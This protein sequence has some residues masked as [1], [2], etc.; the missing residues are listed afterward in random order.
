MERLSRSL[1]VAA[2]PA[3]LQVCLVMDL[4]SLPWIV[5]A[6]ALAL[7]ALAIGLLLSRRSAPTAKPLPTEWALLARPVFSMDERR[8]YRQLREALPH[9]II[10]SK[11]PLVRFCQP[12]DPGSSL[13]VRPAWFHP[14]H[15]RGMQRE[16]PGAGGDRP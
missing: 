1:P 5:A 15:V 14:R 6:L 10:L 4:Q 16:R 9:H 11:L 3:L 12:T 7:L 13:L 2:R 8:V